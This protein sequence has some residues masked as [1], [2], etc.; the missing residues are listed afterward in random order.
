MLDAG[1]VDD[2]PECG[3]KFR[4]PGKQQRAEYEAKLAKQETAKEEEKIL[5]TE[6]RRIAAE[7]KKLRQEERRLQHEDEQRRRELILAE[8][9]E[10]R[11]RN[12]LANLAP[13]T[14][15]GQIV[16][17]GSHGELA[18]VAECPFCGGA[19]FATCQKV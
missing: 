12:E 1:E 18:D 7:E 11:R 17:G 14:V 6:E 9:E 4:V 10:D 8:E 19:R 5:R 13:P 2:C 3:T 16:Q 15:Q